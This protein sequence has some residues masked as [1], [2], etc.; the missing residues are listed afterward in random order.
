MRINFVENYENLSDDE[1]V[2]LINSGNY[3][4]MQVI[5]ERYY[6]V[7]LYNVKNYCPEIYREDA[8]Q[9]ANIA[10]Y[11]A[12]KSFDKAKSSFSTFAT[13]CIKRSVQTVLK[14]HNCKK[15][16][17]DELVYSLEELEIIDHNSPEKIFLDKEGYENLANSIKL[18]LSELEYKVLQLQLSGDSYSVIADKLSIT[19]KAV[20]NS[21]SRVRRKLKSK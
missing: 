20:D 6:P 12:V 17:P 3:E 10:L 9:E 8:V 15:H 4:L 11:T 5:I 13:L 19:E 2:S 21:L 16:I 7:I 1:I 14:T 18:E